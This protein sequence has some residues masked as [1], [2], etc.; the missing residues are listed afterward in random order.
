MTLY[1][2]G[3]LKHTQTVTSSSVFRLPSGYKANEFEFELTG[4]VP[5][6]EVCLYESSE[7]IG[8]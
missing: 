1:A 8:A 6:N 2:E 4:S 7:E 3:V 5:I